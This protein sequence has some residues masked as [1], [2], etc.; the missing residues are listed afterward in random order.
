VPWE[1]QATGPVRLS[2]LDEQA[3]MRDA[4]ARILESA[5][6]AVASAHQ[7]AHAFL[8]ALG[9][10]RPGVALI[11]LALS[12]GGGMTVLEEAHQLFPD[13]RLLVLAPVLDPDVMD[14][15]FRAGAAG[16]L[17]KSSARVEALVDAINAVA[18][19]NNVFP[20][21]AVESL[22]RASGRRS[23]GSEL[24][25]GLSERERE[26]LA[27]LS[28]GADNTQIAEKLKISERTV[29]AHVSNLYRKL[30]QGNRTQL[31]LLARQSGIRPPAQWTPP[32]P[33]VSPPP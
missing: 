24:L 5:G 11:D 20:A 28:V 17:D 31:A 8:T 12:G 10:D 27:Y 33:N 16:Y 2:I 9:H 26:V 30:N 23:E 6:F 3:L 25:R 18:R 19:G 14:R 13:V 7:D 29:K 32:K 1:G 4:L 15:C 22:L 21:H